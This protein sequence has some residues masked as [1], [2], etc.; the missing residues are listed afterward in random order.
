MIVQHYCG[1]WFQLVNSLPH[2]AIRVVVVAASSKRVR[3]AVVVCLLAGVGVAAYFLGWNLWGSYHRQQL[4]AALE[5]RDFAK[6]QVLLNRCFQA[7]P[8]RPELHLIAARIARRRNDLSL[9][10]RELSLFSTNGG[11]DD[12]VLFEQTLALI[13]IGDLTD[14]DDVYRFCVDHPTAPESALALESLI[15]GSLIAHDPQKYRA[16]LDLWEQRYSSAATRSQAKYWQ[17][18]AFRVEQSIGMEQKAYEEAVALNPSS[19]QA[20]LALVERLIDHEPNRAAEHLAIL[21]Q[22]SPGDPHVLYHQALLD[23]NLGR[24]DLSAQNLD[25]ALQKSPRNIDALVLRGR[26]ALEQGQTESAAKYL[27]QAE[28]LLSDHRGV[29]LAMIEYHRATG[30]PAEAERYQERMPENK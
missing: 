4:D 3:A 5:Q 12:E 20:R 15:Q 11:S 30:Q 24:L 23:H 10:S 29:I 16:C 13:Q 14:A 26:I 28:R 17:G 2:P 25:R 7:W 1:R 18:R 8:H 21:Q 19:Q 6:A 9:A 27:H 22:Q